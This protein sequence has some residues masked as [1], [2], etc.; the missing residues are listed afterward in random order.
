MIQT[1]AV[2]CTEV[3]SAA[4]FASGLLGMTYEAAQLTQIPGSSLT[5]VVELPLGKTILWCCSIA[6][7]GLFIAFPLR[8]YCIIER[9]LLFP[10]GTATATVI[11]TLHADP[12]HV[13]KS[14][15]LL[16]LFACITWA[17]SM[18]V[19]AF[20]GLNEFPIFGLTA[21][22]YGWQMDWDLSQF[23][24]GM[25]LGPNINLSILLGGFL[26]SGVIAP[27]VRRNHECAA[28]L[29]SAQPASCWYYSDAP[30]YLDMKAYTLF[31]GVAMVVVDGFYSI[32]K[33]V[34]IVMRGFMRPISYSSAEGE[35]GV[36]DAA[37]QIELIK[38]FTN[39]KIPAWGYIGGYF[40]AI[41]FCICMVTALF[42]VVWWQ[43][44]MA[45]VLTPVFAVGVIIGMGMTN[46]SA[47]SSFGK[48]MMFPLGMLNHGGSVIPSLAVCMITISGC[49]NAAVLMQ[50]FK[51]GYLVGASPR[52]MAIAQMIGA[53]AG[54]LI[55]PCTFHLFRSA[56]LIPN[57]DPH[58]FV[59]G[60]YGP[61]YRALAAI[62]TSDGLNALP[63]G[64]VSFMLGAG[65]LALGLNGGSD[66]A[67]KL[68]PAVQAF[69]PST[70]GI[71]L[72][73]LF[74]PY[75]A[76]DFCLG[77]L[78]QHMWRFSGPRQEKKYSVIVASGCLAGA[79]ISTLCQVFLSL[80]EVSAPIVVSYTAG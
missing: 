63:K 9:K 52:T 60:V 7:F 70:M 76:I 2:A 59:H 46:Q 43:V 8:N 17:W 29:K 36:G 62:T 24:V 73:I 5:D 13:R 14:L 79:G 39:A 11:K 15:K 80:G 55:G 49:G 47:S 51:T 20:Q 42:G 35:E 69:V 57:D 40:L 25:L 19:W 32:V 18:F 22:Q 27:W 72:G 50:D 48:L 78:V 68:C 21:A 58:A 3:T 16:A 61:I 33:L 65:L 71:S 75:I 26:G 53:A 30:K 28:D 4:G 44:L 66:A 74:G 54:C 34:M 64:C 56:F 45:N 31:P 12:S 1:M 77:M 41:S 6:F 38:I 10:S 67:K 23:A 37:T